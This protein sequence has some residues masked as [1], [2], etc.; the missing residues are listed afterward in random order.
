MLHAEAFSSAEV[1]RGPFALIQPDY[2]VLVLGQQ[3]AALDSTQ[4]VCARIRELGGRVLF[5]CPGLET[6]APELVAEQLALPQALHP[7]VDPLLVVQTFYLHVAKLALARGLDP[8][9]P[10][11]LQKVT[12]T[13]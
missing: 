7:L 5:A 13:L 4:Q 3:D 6:V 8:D 9:Q 10:D 11:N 12:Q 1:L 2:P